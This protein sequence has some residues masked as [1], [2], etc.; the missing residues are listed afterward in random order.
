MTQIKRRCPFGASSRIALRALLLQC[1]IRHDSTNI[2]VVLRL[3]YIPIDSILIYTLPP[4]SGFTII[5][6]KDVVE[7]CVNKFFQCLHSFFGVKFYSG[8]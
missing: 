4:G 1:S 6:V 3:R 5:D 7:V 2:L 8:F